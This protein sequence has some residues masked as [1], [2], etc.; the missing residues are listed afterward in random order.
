MKNTYSLKS[1]A[2]TILSSAIFALV[3]TGQQPTGP[4]IQTQADAGRTAYQANCASCHG[5]DLAGSN[6]ASQLAGSLFMGSFGGR[7]TAD[8]LAFMQGAM[9]PGNPGGLGE[10]TYLN[11]AAF[12]LDSNGA[13]PGAQPLTTAAKVEIRSIATGQPRLQVAQAG[14]GGRGAAGRGGAAADGPLGGRAEAPV[15]ATP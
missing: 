14:R 11:I 1:V 7:T 4:Y 6:N 15:P 13:R 12:I 8:L 3:L 10:A 2:L 9:P 5:A